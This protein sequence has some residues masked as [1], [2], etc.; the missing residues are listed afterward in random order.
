MT[1]DNHPGLRDSNDV[2]NTAGNG[3]FVERAAFKTRQGCDCWKEDEQETPTALMQALSHTHIRHMAAIF[4][5]CKC[6]NHP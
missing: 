3:T 5:F 4:F 6:N 1:L 2:S